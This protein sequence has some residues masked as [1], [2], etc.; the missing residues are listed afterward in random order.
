VASQHNFEEGLVSNAALNPH[1]N[2]IVSA[3]EELIRPESTASAVSWGAVI[4]GAVVASA[5]SLALLMLGAGI[6]LISVS[7]WSNNVSVT[8][9]G[10][11]A[12]AWF[13]AV[14]LFAS[15]V[16][17]YL[18]GRLRTRWVRV[19]TDEVYFRDTAHG[20]IVWG[21]GAVVTAWLLASG[22]ASVVSGAAHAGSAALETAGTA[23]AGSAQGAGQA[24]TGQGGPPAYFIDML[25]RTD[26]PD[27]S[28]DSGAARAEVGQILTADS[29]S[30]DMPNADRTY[31]AQVIAARTGLS[32]AD[33]EKRVSDVI[34]QA[35]NA[36]NKAIDAAKAAADAARKTG[37]YVALWAFVSLLIG[38][39]SASY[40]ATVGG[41]IRDDLPMTG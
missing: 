13:I 27:A 19:H 18:T 6:G 23:A 33:A 20:L 11:L 37:V 2:A 34:E 32:Q 36:K 4:A 35:K 17:G 12:A 9:F 3:R 25:F 41:R 10:V 40:M 16:G 14:Q 39:F 21:V 1:S 22:V 31:V 7:P 26:H 28:G 15:G 30:G 38:A 24:A 8:T 5:L 29:V